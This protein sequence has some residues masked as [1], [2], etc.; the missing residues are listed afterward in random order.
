MGGQAKALNQVYPEGM[1]GNQDN[2]VYYSYDPEKAKQLLA[3]AGYPD[4]FKTTFY[5]H[6]VDPF[7]KLAQAIQADL[8]AIGIDAEIK[9]MDKATYWDF[10]S[11]KKS[12]AGIGLTDWYQDFPDPSDWIGP[13]FIKASAV[14]GGAN[15]SFWWDQRVDDLY[16]QAVNELDPRGA[17][18]HVSSRCR[19]SSWTD[20]PSAPLFQPVWNGMYGKNVGGY[21]YHPVWNLNFQDY[22]KLDGK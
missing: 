12:H 15:S 8:K 10:I 17:H 6:N 2:K 18:R 22:W 13:L 20:A 21:Y 5:G 4:G 11:L 16:D 14:D 1:P 7:P 3:E 9:L 19:T